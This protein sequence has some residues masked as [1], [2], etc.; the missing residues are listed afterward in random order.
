MALCLPTPYPMPQRQVGTWHSQHFPSFHRSGLR[1]S[2]RLGSAEVTRGA[3]SDSDVFGSSVTYGISEN[4]SASSSI[5]WPVKVL[6]TIISP[7][8]SV[9][10]GLLQALCDQTYEPGSGC[11]HEPTVPGQTHFR[12]LPKPA[13]SLAFPLTVPLQPSSGP[14]QAKH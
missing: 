9:R 1:G 12:L 13:P 11:V 7:S 6:M 4:K 2:E 3:S 10:V 14:D 5:P 8:L